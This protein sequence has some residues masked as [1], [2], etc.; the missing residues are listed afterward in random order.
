MLE[1]DGSM[2]RQTTLKGKPLNLEGPELKAGDTAPDARLKK[3]LVEETKLS[4]TAGKVRLISVVPSLDTPVCALQTKRFNEEA[5]KLP[6]VSFITVSTDLPTAQARFCG[7]E[8]I[9]KERMAFLS[10]HVDGAFG[11]AWGTLIPDLRVE[12]RAL[13][14]VDKNDQIRYAE[15]VKEVAEH[16]NYDAALQTLK[17]LQ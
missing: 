15:Y 11:K 1:G 7:A 4:D 8:G 9:D 14:V 5:A 12:S 3:N 6:G 2:A 13:F 10:D 17:N 16:P